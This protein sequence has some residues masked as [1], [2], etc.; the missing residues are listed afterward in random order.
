MCLLAAIPESAI[1][2][3]ADPDDQN[4]DGVS[5]RLQRVVD[6]VSSQMRVGRFGWKAGQ[7]SVRDQV[8]AALNTDIGVMTS[9]FPAPDCGSSQSNC[10]AAAIEL[11]SELLEQLTAYISLLGVRARRDLDDPLALQGET[12]FASIGCAACH[13]PSHETSAFHP[14]AE[15]RAQT[16]HPYTDLLLH[17]MGDGLADS[18][19]EG[20]ASGAEWRTPPLWGI[21]LGAGVSEGAAYL[22]DGRARTLDEAIR[23]HGGEGATA[24]QAYLSLTTAQRSAI[25]AFLNS[26]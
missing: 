16:I 6:P 24:Q 13:T 23:W 1:E 17:D 26:L 8:A 25:L 22:H 11:D 5:G 3:L 18:L 10:G 21:G 9:V 20:E 12:L 2:A 14:H 4:A 7:A 15:L 19:G